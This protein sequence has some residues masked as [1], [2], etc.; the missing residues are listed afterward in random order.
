[1]QDALS[2]LN[3]ALKLSACM[4]HVWSRCAAVSVQA[5]RRALLISLGALGV[6]V[7]VANKLM[8]SDKARNRRERKMD[9]PWKVFCW[10]CSIVCFSAEAH[11]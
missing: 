1:M 6:G 5:D 10:L 7:A 8:P 3:F 9:D 4:S 11:T 2:T